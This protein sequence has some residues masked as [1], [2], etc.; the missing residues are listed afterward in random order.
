MSKGNHQFVCFL[1]FELLQ[2]IAFSLIEVSH[3]LGVV[4]YA[5]D[6]CFQLN[7]VYFKSIFLVLVLRIGDVKSFLQ[8]F[9]LFLQKVKLALY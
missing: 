1:G 6:F 7:C 4:N 2:F 8:S 3:N 9:H 5:L